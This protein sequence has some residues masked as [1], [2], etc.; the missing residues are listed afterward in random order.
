MHEGG[1]RRRP[2]VVTEGSRG[3]GVR[4]SGTFTRMRTALST[5]VRWAS[6]SSRTR[7]TISR[8]WHASPKLH[9][10]RSPAS[11]RRLRSRRSNRHTTRRLVPLGDRRKPHA[12]AWRP[13]GRNGST[14]PTARTGGRLE[15]RTHSA[16]L[17]SRSPR[18]CEAPCGG[19][20]VGRAVRISGYGRCDGARRNTRDRCRA[21]ACARAAGEET[22]VSLLRSAIDRRVPSAYTKRNR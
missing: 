2:L 17:R 19:T 15:P 1:H 16:T 4:S 12:A 7:R 9:P 8:R 11:R 6:P 21:S 18:T 10:A 20:C 22:S 14:A 3:L 13:R 5:P